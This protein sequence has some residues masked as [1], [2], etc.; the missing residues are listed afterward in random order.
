M[1]LRKLLEIA[2]DADRPGR[3]EIAEARRQLPAE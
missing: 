3:M 2:G 1:Y